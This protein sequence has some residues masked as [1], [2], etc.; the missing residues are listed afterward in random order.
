MINRWSRSLALVA[1][2]A[3]LLAAHPTPVVE[4]VKK[5]DVLRQTLPQGDKLF[6]RTVQLGKEDVARIEQEAHYTPDD[7]DVRFYLGKDGSGV[8]NGVVLFAQTNTKHGPVEVGLTFGADGAL[9]SAIVTK[10]TV[11]TKPWV[12]KAVRAGLMKEFEGMQYGGDVGAP[13]MGSAY[14]DLGHMPHY[15]A[16]VIAAT[17]GRGLILHHLLYRIS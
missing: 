11:E 16:E 2:P 13:L 9:S 12:L 4:L 8:V 17:V 1:L 5:V 14:T 3:M 7:P 10:A 15:M 6:V